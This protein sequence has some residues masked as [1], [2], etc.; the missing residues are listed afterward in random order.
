MQV[1]LHQWARADRSRR[2]D[3]LY[4]L[5]C[6][7]AFL[8]EA[9]QRVSTNSG[10]RT[11][12]IDGLTVAAIEHRL[13]VQPFLMEIRDELKA[14]TY[15][16]S[17]VRRTQI[18]K[19]NGKLRDLG[20]PTVKDRIVQA[21]LKA[22][23]EPIFEAD[24]LPV[25]YGFRP[26]RR[27][28]DAIEEIVYL[29]R[30]GYHVVLEADIE[31]CFDQID[32]A[33]L[34]DRIRS[35]ISDKRVLALVKAF[36]KAGVMNHGLFKDSLT[37]APQGGI[38]SPLLANIALTA[39]DEH[40]HTQWH[41]LMGTDYQR[42]KRRRTG[43]GNWRLIRYA[44]DFVVMVSGPAHHAEDL[45]E[46]I[47]QVLARLG[48]RLSAE[49]TRVVHID[50]GFDF[51][52]QNIRRQRKRGTDKLVVYTKPSKKAIKAIKDRV[53]ERTHGHTF[54]Q[55]LGTLLAS[56]NRTLAGWAN[57]FRHGV[58]KKTFAAI[59]HHAWQR[60]ARWLLRKHRIPR[61]Q[62]RRF[63]D[64][65]WRFAEGSVAFRGASSVAIV[66]YRYRGAAIPTP[67]TIEPAATPG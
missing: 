8:I 25:S 47:A 12:G 24:F 60:I 13:G 15:R 62:L 46:Q 21:A 66:R 19:S 26:N 7:P 57:Y 63:C 39:L 23:L 11:A 45:R 58:S 54:N 30:R 44:D 35:R 42:T 65:G 56:V 1:K 16:P 6:D 36:L 67:W 28:Q 20:I 3:D 37:G 2:F 33:A 22:V 29:A 17:P 48:L 64:Q 40:F 31:A 51:L 59:D 53:S 43:Q 10:A 5:V 55:S 34:M 27:A 14:R 41:T 32:H 18:P 52:G 49:K 50:D 38:L 61:S 4:N 9:W